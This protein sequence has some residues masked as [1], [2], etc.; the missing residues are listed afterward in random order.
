MGKRDSQPHS[1]HLPRA[2]RSATLASRCTYVLRSG[3]VCY[4]CT[5]SYVESEMQIR[6][7]RVSSAK[8]VARRSARQHSYSSNTH[9]HCGPTYVC[10]VFHSLTLGLAPGRTPCRTAAQCLGSARRPHTT[11]APLFG[12]VEDAMRVPM[13]PCRHAVHIIRDCVYDCYVEWLAVDV[14]ESRPSCA[15]HDQPPQH[16]QTACEAHL[17]RL[18]PQPILL[19]HQCTT[20]SRRRNYVRGYSCIC[21]LRSRLSQRARAR[22]CERKGREAQHRLPPQACQR[23]MQ[24]G[25]AEN[26]AW[27]QCRD[28]HRRPIGHRPVQCHCEPALRIAARSLSNPPLQRLC[29]QGSAARQKPERRMSM[30]AGEGRIPPHVLAYP[31]TTGLQNDPH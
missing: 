7:N 15:P 30:E 5:G 9:H 24:R 28:R 16:G 31:P 14:R 2:S 18:H 20:S 3:I 17:H 4:V 13:R 10:S 23:G 26:R 12:S 25:R 8:A 22:T 19:Q 29:G 11:A 21:A 1:P 6:S 27:H